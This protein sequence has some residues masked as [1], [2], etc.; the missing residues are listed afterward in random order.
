[1][2]FVKHS[3]AV[4]MFAVLTGCGGGSSNNTAPVDTTPDTPD[5]VTTITSV[6]PQTAIIGQLTTFTLSGQK[7]S[8]SLQVSLPN[9]Q[10]ISWVASPTTAAKFTCTPQAEGTQVLTVKNATGT[11]LFTS[12]ITLQATAPVEDVIISSVDIPTNITVGKITSFTLKGQNLS[13]TLKIDLPQCQN[14]TP[15]DITS[16]QSRFTCTPQL[17]S[18]Q[19]LNIYDTLGN[20]L[21]T[22]IITIRNPPPTLSG[23]WRRTT[24]NGCTGSVEGESIAGVQSKLPLFTF[25]Q[26]TDSNA[27]TRLRLLDNEG[28]SYLS[29]DCSVTV[30]ST[31][32]TAKSAS[33]TGIA[34]TAAIYEDVST[35]QQINGFNYYSLKTAYSNNNTATPAAT[36]IVFKD[37]NTFCFFDGTVTP[38]NISQFIQSVDTTKIGCFAR[39]NNIPFSQTPPSTLLTTST[40]VLTARNDG[41]LL[42][43]VVER[44]NQRGQLGYQLL[45]EGKLLSPELNTSNKKTYDVLTQITTLSDLKFTYI[46]K[47]EPS[48]NSDFEDNRLAQLNEFGSQN[49]LF[50]GKKQLDAF[51]GAKTLYVKNNL[52]EQLAYLLRSDSDVNA[53]KLISILDAQGQTG[54]RFV[55]IRLR[56]TTANTYTTVCVNSSRNTGTFSYRYI[57]Y[58]QS[59]RTDALQALLEE[60]KL[61]GFYP[62]RTMNIATNATVKLLFER[63]SSIAQGI[64]DMQYKVYS[65]ALP[66]N[67]PEVASLLNDQG[68]IGWHLWS[69]MNGADNQF[70][71]TIFASL[72]FPHLPDGEPAIL[73][74]R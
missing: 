40:S 50:I 66:S 47:D 6:S 34:K 29:N 61:E 73:D 59:T 15:L 8:D 23:S 36:A 49:L 46:P 5:D 69:Q 32:D 54:C 7:L 71:A 62:I 64:Q 33:I 12:N 13:S 10:D 63:D 14:I 57:D 41:E 67:Q 27:D 30:S 72:P 35:A 52:S 65:Q 20:T 60:Q 1:M 43:N 58:P 44:L 55:D 21:F 51:F 9:C 38:T 68:K 18:Q 19:T 74:R 2:H 11:T 24:A 22:K 28:I 25:I 42:L 37:D 45:S 56:A 31:D 3:L 48:Q 53:T 16:A 39:S 4:A 70:L 26:N 17:A